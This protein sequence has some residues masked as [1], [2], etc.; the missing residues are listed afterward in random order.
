[1]KLNA[2]QREHLARSLQ[3]LAVGQFA[4]FG[5]HAAQSAKFGWLAVSAAVY[6]ILERAATYMLR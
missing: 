2:K 1:M 5:Y 6:F 4:F 3:T